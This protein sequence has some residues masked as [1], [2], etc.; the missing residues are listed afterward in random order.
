L[1]NELIKWTWTKWR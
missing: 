1:N